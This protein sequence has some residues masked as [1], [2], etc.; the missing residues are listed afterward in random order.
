[1]KQLVYPD[2]NTVGNVGW[3]LSFVEDAYHTPHLYA[4]ATQAWNATL[5]AHT[6]RD[7]PD[8]Q[9]PVWFSYYEDGINYG[10]VAINVPGRGVLSSPY[11]KDGTQQWFKDIDECA[12]VL[13]CTYLGWS[14]DLATIKLVEGETMPYISQE[15]LDDYNYWKAIGMQL[16]YTKAW[17]AIGGDP[18]QVQPIYNDLDM[19]ATFVKSSPAWEEN[20]GSLAG[21]SVVKTGDAPSATILKT[22]VYEVK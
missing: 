7:L 5:Y 18:S 1:M 6:N 21:L 16:S 2:L 19:Y 3:C 13:N 8:V 10:H 15:A 9:V 14:E 22:G 12:R 4:T 17:P 20:E 11:K